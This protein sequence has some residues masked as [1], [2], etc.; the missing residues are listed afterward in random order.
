MKRRMVKLAMLIAALCFSLPLG[1]CRSQEHGR[2]PAHRSEGGPEA[3]LVQPSPDIGTLSV[4]IF[5]S[6]NAY[7]LTGAAQPPYAHRLVRV[8]A[9]CVL[10]LSECP[11][12]HVIEAYPEQGMTP[13]HLHWAPDGRQALFLDTYQPRVLRFDPRDESIVT[14]MDDVPTIR[15]DLVWMSDGRAAF[16]IQ[17]EGDYASSLVA[18]GEDEGTPRLQVLASFDGLAYLLGTDSA[19]RLLVSLDVY[20][21]PGSETSSKEIVVEV[22]LVAVDPATGIVTEEWGEVDWLSQTP[23]GVLPD[24][25]RLVFGMDRI[26]L[27]DLQTGVATAVGSHLVWPT[28]SPD[29]RWLAMVTV[30]AGGALF[31]VRAV[32]LE[33]GHWRDLTSLSATPKLFWSPDSRYLIM[34]R[35]GLESSA[36]LGSMR[37][38]AIDGGAAVTPYLDLGEYPVVEDVS[39][40][41]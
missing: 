32:E 11:Q 8:P 16:V 36:P 1:A 29:G 12:P 37:V 28:G 3:G 5:P 6:G 41:P 30:H 22:R 15:D 25:R 9:A 17:G 33:T 35:L 2:E 27:W 19:G 18:L 34:A 40:G 31:T 26:S 7:L 14:L 21:L 39:W 24:G 13:S 20:G 4:A 10:A 23:Q 38:A